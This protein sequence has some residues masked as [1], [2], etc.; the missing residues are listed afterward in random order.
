MSNVCT[1]P[2]D[3][4]VVEDMLPLLQWN[5]RLVS[6]LWCKGHHKPRLYRI[7][8]ALSPCSELGAP[9]TMQIASDWNKPDGQMCIEG[10]RAEVLRFLHDLPVRKVRRA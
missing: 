7:S 5:A 10:D 6:G 9:S 2:H 8:T 4:T 1:L 3:K